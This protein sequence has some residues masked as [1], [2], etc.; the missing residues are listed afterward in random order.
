MNKKILFFLLFVT[1]FNACTKDDSEG[2]SLDSLYG[3]FSIVDS[4]E[5]ST[6]TPD[7]SNN[8]GVTFYSKFTTIVD[9][10]ISIKGLSSNSIKEFS[11]FSNI[12]DPE[13]VSW[14]GN[15]S[16][17]PFFQVE[18]C[19]IELTF[20][21]HPDT[22]RDSLTV[23]GTKTYDGILVANF[24]DNLPE[25]TLVWKQ[26]GSNMTFET[27][28]DNPLEGNTY[29]KMGGKVGWDWVLGS[30]DIPLTNLSE[31]TT[32]PSNFFLNLGIFSGINGAVADNQFINIL[33]TESTAPFND[34]LSNNASDVFEENMEVYLYKIQ[35]VDWLGWQLMTLSYDQFE[36]KNVSNASVTYDRNPR[37]ITA[38]R[39]Q[40]KACPYN[41]ASTCPNN[42]FIDVRTDIDY[43]VFTENQGLLD[44]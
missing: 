22:L 42:E 40:C 18:D 34:N 25:N 29:F 11:G 26:T 14:N 23:L 30:I 36:E 5:I 27:S 7:F 28:T 43:I 32:N 17:V 1:C 33:I 13:V 8:E 15:T 16:Q 6:N 41:A 10:K 2:P 9:W 24:E 19:A 37:D 20:E 35:P 39:I 38:I 4:L 31:V 3:T 21:N 12:I 44:Q